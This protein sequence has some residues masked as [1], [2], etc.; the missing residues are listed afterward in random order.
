MSVPQK[1]GVYCLANDD[2]LEWFEAFVRSLRK[3]SPRLP[4]TVIPYNASMTQLKAL[5]PQFNFT[6]MS[7]EKAARFD[8]IAHRVAGKRIAGG[9]FR[10]LCCFFGIYDS[11]LFLD[12]DIVVT[13]SLEPFFDAFEKA[14]GDFVYFDAD[15]TMAYTPEFAR[16]MAEKYG[17][18]GFISGS[19][20]AR[21]NGVGEAEIMAA[22]ETGESI[23]DGFS[24]WG[25]QPFMNYLLDVTRK[26]KLAASKLVSNITDLPSAM[27]FRYDAKRDMYIDPRGRLLPFIHWAGGE[28]PTMHRPEVFLRYRTLGMNWQESLA[29]RLNFYY[30]RFRWNLK[31]AM[32]RFKPTARLLAWRENFK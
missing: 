17:S 11:F 15:I 16:Q 31:Q 2:V 22:V 26:H 13:Q 18:V 24:I 1:K 27:D 3:H 29:Y 30:C 9:T 5:Q 4:L 21:H 7:E 14:A 19:W 23:R 12:S 6:V 25:E 20:M 32:L 10:K 28:Y 8:P